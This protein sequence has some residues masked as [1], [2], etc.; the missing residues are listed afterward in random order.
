MRKPFATIIFTGFLLTFL[1]NANYAFAID[2]LDIGIFPPILEI[3]ATPPASAQSLI[4]LQ[5]QNETPHNF[6]ITVRPFKQ[7]SQN[8]GQIE[9]PQ[10]IDFQGPDP[11]LRQKIHFFDGENEIQTIRLEPLESKDI[12][13]QIDLDKNSPLGD[14]YFSVIFVTEP[15]QGENI[16]NTKLPAGIATNVLLSIGPK[17]D[18]TGFIQNFKTPI[19]LEHGPVP[20]TVS[21]ENTSDHFIIPEGRINIK[22]IFGQP[23]A[24]LDLLPQ[25]ILSGSRRYLIDQNQASASAE[26]LS[27]IQSLKQSQPIVVWPEKL[28]LGVYTA[29]LRISLGEKGPILKQTIVFFAFPVIPTLG[30]SF[31]FMIILGISLRVLHK[32]PKAKVK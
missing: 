28:L 32:F 14:Y 27:T 12:I 17:G 23:V 2:D 19:F 16:S 25:Y 24:K 26:L 29:D 22:N 15:E 4:S 6:Q 20:F 1:I 10:N 13:M 7:S 18:T 21:I 31:L 5:N 11:F 3:T 30:I 8:N 9:Y